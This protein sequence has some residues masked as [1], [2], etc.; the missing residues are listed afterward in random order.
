MNFISNSSYLGVSNHL[1]EK[2]ES[3]AIEIVQDIINKL[4]QEFPKE[5]VDQG[6][7]IYTEFMTFLGESLTFN[8]EEIPED[9][10]SWSKRVGEHEASLR[11]RISDVVVLYP[12]IRVIFVEHITKISLEYGLSAEEVAFVLKRIGYILDISINETILAFERLKDKM[13]KETQ[14]E[15]NILSA[16]IVPLQDGLA[17]LPLIGSIDT[18]RAKYLLENT[19]PRIAELKVKSIIIDFSGILVI[20]TAVANHIFKI[21][22]V[23]RLLGIDTIATGIRPELAQTVVKSG[24]D[25]SS[26]K[27]YA[28]VQQALEDMK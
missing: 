25:F 1:I 13:I 2:A 8:E 11:G 15:V 17:V 12:T 28:N 24:M 26:I 20:D 7:V 6:I 22:D 27:T 3:L 9:L 14:E 23:L 5:E 21:H 4:E 10:I 18:N 16:P 19:V